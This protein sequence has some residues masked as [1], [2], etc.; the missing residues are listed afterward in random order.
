ME[1]RKK[2]LKFALPSI[3]SMWA[4]SLY[5]MVDGVFLKEEGRL[6]FDERALLEEGERVQKRLLERGQG[7]AKVV[8]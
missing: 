2:F 1:L 8:Y 6:V 4:F 7:Q 3:A 5:T